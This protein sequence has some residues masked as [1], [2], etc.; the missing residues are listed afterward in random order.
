[1][2]L[3]PEALLGE[4][5]AR[6][7][8]LGTPSIAVPPIVVARSPLNLIVVP[9]GASGAGKSGGNVVSRELLPTERID[10]RDGFLLGSGEGIADAFL[11]DP[12]QIDD[13]GRKRTIRR[14]LYTAMLVVVDEGQTMIELGSPEGST[15]IP[16]LR[17][18]WSGGTLGQE[19]ASSERWRRVE[20]GAYS[21][22][23][24]VAMQPKYAVQLL[25][26]AAGGTPEL[27][28]GYPP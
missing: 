12:E 15:L 1:M 23:A 21:F 3:V 20:T 11:G 24:V 8:M 27:D 5:L 14:Q 13:N 18:V 16:R 19:N 6:V 10:V 17:T 28:R 4:V 9:V 2:D 26:D 7:V 22:A 25:N